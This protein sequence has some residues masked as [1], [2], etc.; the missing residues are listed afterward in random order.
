MSVISRSMRLTSA[1]TMS[2]SRAR[3]SSSVAREN[4]STALL[5]R[6]Q[7]VLQLVRHVGGEAFD[8]VDAVVQ[9][10]GHGRQAL[11]KIADLVVAVRRCREASRAR[12][13]RGARGR[14]PRPACASARRWCP[15]DRARTPA[16]PRTRAA[17]H[18]DQRGALLAQDVVDVAAFGGN[19]QHAVDRL[20]ALH[21]HGHGEHELV[22]L[23]DAL[24]R[25]GVALQ[26]ARRPR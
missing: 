13:G 24:G 19:E 12:R 4:I 8:G 21:R 5:Q 23:V 20:E 2:I 26:R 11:R 18:L 6:G 1:R 3:D 14:P 9:R 7:R 22:L 17:K 25:G 16:S 10:A 15:T